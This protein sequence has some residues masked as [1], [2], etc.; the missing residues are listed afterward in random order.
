[1]QRWGISRSRLP[2]G[3][4]IL[5]REP[6]A[7]EKYRWQIVLAGI[8]FLAQTGLIAGLLHEHRRRRAAEVE[9]RASAWP[10]LL[11]STARRPPVSCR[12]RLLM[13]STSHWEP[14]SATP[15]PWN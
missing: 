6:T 10:S 8:V 11:I 1:M 5:F 9:S 13:N 4:Q 7:W 3:S 12:L 2:L 14:F 15:K